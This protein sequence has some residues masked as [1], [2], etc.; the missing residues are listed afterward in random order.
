MST[1]T[2]NLRGNITTHASVDDNS[3][4]I[5]RLL[6]EYLL[7]EY[8]ASECFVYLDFNS[9]G[10][11]FSLTSSVLDDEATIDIDTYD[12]SESK[13]MRDC[14]TWEASSNQ[15]SPADSSSTTNSGA[16]ISLLFSR[17]VRSGRLIFSL[18]C[19]LA[20]LFVCLFVRMFECLWTGNFNC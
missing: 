2:H 5:D 19:M 16:L 17:T 15:P 6:N 10:F 9:C 12:V 1:E 20:C 18:W 4:K 8:F 13:T 14:L 3:K 7:L 11:V